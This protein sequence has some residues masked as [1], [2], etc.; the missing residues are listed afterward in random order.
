MN[1]KEIFKRITDLIIDQL[2]RGTIPWRKPWRQGL[3]SN[4]ITK[5]PYNGINRLMLLTNDY[6]SAYYLTYLQVKSLNGQ[7]HKGE[8][9]HLIVFWKIITLKEDDEHTEFPLLRYSYVFN[10]AQ[11]TLYNPEIQNNNNTL[12]DCERL[13]HQIR[14]TP[15]IRNNISQ[16]FYDK[17]KD[18]ISIPPISEFSSSEE[19]YSSL[20]HELIHWTGHRSRLNRQG[21]DYATEELVAEIGSSFL[22]ALTGI[23]RNVLDN[24][25][26]YIDFWIK[27]VSD[28]QG[29]IFKASHLAQQAADFLTMYIIND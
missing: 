11:T 4:Y 5:Q 12:I 15:I 22:C 28:N 2:K 25:A 8:K 6:P 13:I 23:E 7:I 14:P 1:R 9:G 18:Y 10:L 3:P 21:P 24:Q 17:A 20:F 16:C 29:I 27:Q 26:A 19:Y